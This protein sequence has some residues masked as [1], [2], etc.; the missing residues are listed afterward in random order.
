ME[1]VSG[2]AN[3]DGVWN[4]MQSCLGRA[5]MFIKKEKMCLEK[6]ILKGHDENL[7]RLGVHLTISSYF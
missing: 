4:E 2:K 3:G 1:H 5:E 6:I 7:R